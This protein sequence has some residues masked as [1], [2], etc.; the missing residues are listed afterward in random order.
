MTFGALISCLASIFSPGPRCFSPA[1]PANNDEVRRIKKIYLAFE[2][3]NRVKMLSK[4]RI[5]FVKSLQIK[6]YRKQ[7]QCFLV[8]GAKY[9]QEFLR[10][11][12]ETLFGTGNSSFT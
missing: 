12:F 11:E 9:M 6:K 4:A 7:E 3:A 5:K 8:Q 2:P 1:H 10:S